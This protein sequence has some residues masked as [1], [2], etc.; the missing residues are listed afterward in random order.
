MFKVT[1]T[2]EGGKLRIT[3]YIKKKTAKAGTR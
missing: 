1:F 3:I 2:F